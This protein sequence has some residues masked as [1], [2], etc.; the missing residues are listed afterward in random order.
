MPQQR[1]LLIHGRLD[2]L[3]SDDRVLL[4]SDSP[5]DQWEVDPYFCGL[6]LY[7]RNGFK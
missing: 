4:V 1:R 3:V 6:G 7:A 5:G 2:G